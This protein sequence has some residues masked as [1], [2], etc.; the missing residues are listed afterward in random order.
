MSRLKLLYTCV[1]NL[2]AAIKKKTGNI[3][4]EFA[5][6]TQKDDRNIIIYHNKLEETADKITTVLKHAAALI[7]WADTKKLQL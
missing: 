1:A 4:E 5:H 6:Y 7:K 2:V 3:A